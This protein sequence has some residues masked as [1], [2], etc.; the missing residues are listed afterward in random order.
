[1]S[2]TVRLGISEIRHRRYKD[3]S[4]EAAG[5]NIR[6]VDIPISEK[7]S[8]EEQVEQRMLLGKLQH[9]IETVLTEKQRTV[10]RAVLA[11][12]PIEETAR[13]MGSNRNAV[14]KLFHDAR[15]RLKDGLEEAQYSKGD[16]AATFSL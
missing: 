4:L 16:I 3:V 14:Y 8:A 13:R 7:N 9:L 6:V 15:K 5:G 2:I 11:G 1:M 10:V 12:L